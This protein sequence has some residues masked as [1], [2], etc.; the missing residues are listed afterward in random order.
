MFLSVSNSVMVIIPPL[1]AAGC[2]IRGNNEL[3][4][5]KRWLESRTS[6]GASQAKFNQGTEAGYQKILSL[7]LTQ[8]CE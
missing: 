1:A 4:V 5:D 3:G 2:T 7:I 8:R 6:N